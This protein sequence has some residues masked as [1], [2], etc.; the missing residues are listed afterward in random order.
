MLPCGFAAG[1][2]GALPQAGSGEPYL[3][4]RDTSAVAPINATT[5]ANVSE[6]FNAWFSLW[7]AGRAAAPDGLGRQPH[8]RSFR[9]YLPTVE[10]IIRQ[11]A[12]SHQV[13]R[14]VK[15]TR[16]AIAAG[17][18]S[19]ATVSKDRRALA[20]DAGGARIE[21]LEHLI[22]ELERPGVRA[23]KRTCEDPEANPKK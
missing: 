6:K 8:S 22:A 17:P 11:T 10:A 20:R 16:L 7:R 9:G 2:A 1:I 5:R 4:R 14:D 19:R 3:S 21:G 13:T 15:R 23:G 12:A 18:R